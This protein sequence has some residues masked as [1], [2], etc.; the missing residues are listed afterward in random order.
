MLEKGLCGII[1]RRFMDNY[2]LTLI[3]KPDLPEKERDDFV[4][5]VEKW[6]LEGK[7]KVVKKDVLGKRLLAYRIKKC[8]EGIYVFMALE[9]VP[10]EVAVLDKK[11]K[12]EEKVIRY[13]IVKV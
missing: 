13:L 6:V 8:L 3:L 1:K 2:E 11:L 7:G 10:K 5:K 9:M 4:A 12:L